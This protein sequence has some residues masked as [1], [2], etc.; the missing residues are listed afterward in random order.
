MVFSE[1][2]HT[3]SKALFDIPDAQSAPDQMFRLFNED[4]RL[5]ALGKFHP[6]KNGL[7]PCLVID[8]GGSEL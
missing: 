5:L 6:E 7:H 2:I 1:H 4:G 8:S 3:Q